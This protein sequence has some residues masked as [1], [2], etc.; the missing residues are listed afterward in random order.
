MEV[1]RSTLLLEGEPAGFGI[2]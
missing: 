2:F 1:N